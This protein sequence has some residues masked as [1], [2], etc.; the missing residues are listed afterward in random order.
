MPSP[1]ARRVFFRNP[2]ISAPVLALNPSWL[3]TD[4]TV[5]FLVNTDGSVKSGDT[6]RLQVQSSGGDWSTLASNTTETFASSPTSMASAS[7]SNGTYQAR[8]FVFRGGLLSGISN[9]LTFT[10]ASSST[11]VAAVFISEIQF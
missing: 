6:I 1:I 4:D 8:C 2:K 9:T 5:D 10:V 3:S 11:G 7:L